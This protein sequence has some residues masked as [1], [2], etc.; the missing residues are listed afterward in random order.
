MNMR[1]ADKPRKVEMHMVE[2]RCESCG[3]PLDGRKF[4]WVWREHTGCSKA[5]VEAC[6][7]FEQMVDDQFMNGD[8]LSPDGKRDEAEFL[9][10]PDGGEVGK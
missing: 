10:K 2:C 1:P 6:V 5:C 7:S 8:E 4:V 9:A 3:M